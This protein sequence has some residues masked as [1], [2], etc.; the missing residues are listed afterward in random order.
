M[1]ERVARLNS[2]FRQCRAENTEMWI[3]CK[4]THTYRPPVPKD[5]VGL[6]LG[7]HYQVRVMAIH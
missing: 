5:S 3:L 4:E 7:V 1:V 6:G 2:E